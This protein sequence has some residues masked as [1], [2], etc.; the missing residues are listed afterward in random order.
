[1]KKKRIIENWNLYVITDEQLG[2]GRTH[3]ELAREAIAGGAEVIQLRDKTASGK[4]LYEVGREL[5]RLTQEKKVTFII[6]DRVDLAMLVEADGVHVGQTDLPS[7]AVRRLIG[8][9]KI[10]GVSAASV[11]EA[12]QAEA[13]GA[14]YLGVGPIFE[15]RGTKSDAGNPLGLEIL[16]HIRNKCHL[17]LVAIG[18]INRENVACVIQSGA[19]AVAIISAIISAENVSESARQIKSIILKEKNIK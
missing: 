13:D 4:K 9:G 15:A 3:L 5:R 18:G 12:L 14:D 19:D 2:R 1:M 6:N 17:P 11:S 10:L 7:R 8:P 16:Q